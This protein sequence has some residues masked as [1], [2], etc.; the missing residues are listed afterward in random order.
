VPAIG[1]KFRLIAAG[2]KPPHRFAEE[3]KIEK[4][5]AEIHAPRALQRM[6]WSSEP[7]MLMRM[8]PSY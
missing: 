5:C 2:S 6:A 4:R 7:P 3:F 1:E 8:P